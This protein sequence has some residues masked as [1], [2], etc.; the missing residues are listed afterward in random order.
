VTEEVI[1]RELSDEET[2][3]VDELAVQ[4]NLSR[5]AMIAALAR[6]GLDKWEREG[7]LLPPGG[8]DGEPR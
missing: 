3:R 7:V 5:E 4:R 1:I 2:A 8:E 6:V